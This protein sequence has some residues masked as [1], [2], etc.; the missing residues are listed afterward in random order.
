MSALY[1]AREV[2]VSY[3]KG[4]FSVLNKG[5]SSKWKTVKH[6]TG[7]LEL[8]K[9]LQFD[10]LFC[11]CTFLGLKYF[12]PMDFKRSPLHSISI[13]THNLKAE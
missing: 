6:G 9:S 12:L 1:D 3:N 11:P 7:V 4:M 8:L 13:P 10:P 5:Y 2:I